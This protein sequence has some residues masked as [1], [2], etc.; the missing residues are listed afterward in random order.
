MMNLITCSLT[1]CYLY[2]ICRYYR[3]HLICRKILGNYFKVDLW[4]TC[5]TTST[6]FL[7]SINQHVLHDARADLVQ[8]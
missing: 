1:I 3:C 6:H 4:M 5:R 8:W 7:N 2:L